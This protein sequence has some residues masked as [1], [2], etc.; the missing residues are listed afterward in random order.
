MCKYCEKMEGI[1]LKKKN[2]YYKTIGEYTGDEKVLAAIM[3]LETKS[4]FKNESYLTVDVN[5]NKE[6]RGNWLD[7]KINY[8]PFCGKS[9]KRKTL[10]NTIKAIIEYKWRITHDNEIEKGA[11]ICSKC[12][13]KINKKEK[14]ITWEGKKIYCEKCSVKEGKK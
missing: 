9:L 10:S 3:D 7:V 1:W 8:C 14:V 4:F 13:K 11:A 12:G 5:Y 6:K 2:I